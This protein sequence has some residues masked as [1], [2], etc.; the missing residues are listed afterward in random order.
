MG[1]NPIE[2]VGIGNAQGKEADDCQ[3]VN[4]IHHERALLSVDSCVVRT[5]IFLALAG[6]AARGN[7]RFVPA[8]LDFANLQLSNDLRQGDIF[9]RPETIADCPKKLANCEIR[10]QGYRRPTMVKSAKSGSRIVEL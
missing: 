6:E 7:A 1:S 8:I 3:N 4:E 10:A 2:G 9:V 5:A